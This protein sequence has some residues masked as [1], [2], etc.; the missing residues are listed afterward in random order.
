MAITEEQTQLNRKAFSD[1][2]LKA[3][4]SG[5][6]KEVL[7]VRD[8]LTREERKKAAFLLTERLLGHQW[9]YLS[10]VVLGFVSYGSEIDTK[11]I[12]EEALRK[13]K[14]LYVPR[15]EGED[16]VFYR[17]CSLNELTEGYK[18]ILEPEGTTEIF[19]YEEQAADKALM[20]MP[21]AVFDRQRNR[22]GYGLGFYDKY[23]ADKEAL[24][25]RTIAVGFQC[26][27]LDNIPAGAED[28]KPYQVICV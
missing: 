10:E 28:I 22:I 24:Q 20:L 13:G 3:E 6:R 11:E 4:K 17:I 12:L 9:F 15:V 25:L 2:A 23:L 16:M 8:A 18:G 27:L 19:H 21:G 1:K 5:L 7:A 14:K 26:Q